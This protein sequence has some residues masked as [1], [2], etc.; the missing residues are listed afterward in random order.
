MK[1]AS[2][3]QMFSWGHG[4]RWYDKK[5]KRIVRRPETRLRVLDDVWKMGWS[6][7]RM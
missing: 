1:D 3:G 4:R 7:V 6:G 2:A 5:S